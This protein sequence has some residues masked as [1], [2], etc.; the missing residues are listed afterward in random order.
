MYFVF[1]C[2]VSVSIAYHN[3]VHALLFVKF[4]CLDTLSIN[5][6]SHSSCYIRFS[7]CVTDS[8]KKDAL[9]YFHIYQAILYVLS[10][11]SFSHYKHQACLYMRSVKGLNYALCV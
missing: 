4:A 2:T 6:S 9:S 5:Y 7:L 8:F 1:E 11:F 3:Y 10:I